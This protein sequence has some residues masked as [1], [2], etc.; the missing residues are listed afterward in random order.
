MEDLLISSFLGLLLGF[1][2][3]TFLTYFPG[4]P[5]DYSSITNEETDLNVTNGPGDAPAASAN[6]LE[7][8]NGIS[9]DDVVKRTESL[10]KFL[11][12]SEE[13]VRQSVRKTKAEHAKS[14][15]SEERVM[16]IDGSI[17]WTKILD[18]IVYSL[19]LIFV[20]AAI[21]NYS[22]GNLLKVLWGI[23]PQEFET[24][25]LTKR[26]AEYFKEDL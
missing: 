4:K 7:Q 24:L 12:L 18:W 13:D 6:Y 8:L 25:G 15:R 17:S 20:F 1:S 9:E 5:Y 11:G 16:D 2:I 23:F 10:Q 21:N 14:H 26:M 22:R 19:F 3:I